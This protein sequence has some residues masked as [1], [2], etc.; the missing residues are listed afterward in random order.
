MILK[1]SYFSFRLLQLRVVVC[2]LLL[3]GG[4]VVNLFIPMV[5]RDIGENYSVNFLSLF[6]CK[7]QIMFYWCCPGYGFGD[8]KYHMHFYNSNS[9]F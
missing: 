2:F 6:Y 8:E 5:Y 9:G 3:G 1:V 4:R 7:L